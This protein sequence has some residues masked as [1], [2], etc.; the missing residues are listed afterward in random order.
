V[1]AADGGPDKKQLQIPVELIRKWA[2]DPTFG[3][4]FNEMLDRTPARLP[5]SFAPFRH[6]FP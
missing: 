2:M 4:K 5:P 3:N 1:F 6:V